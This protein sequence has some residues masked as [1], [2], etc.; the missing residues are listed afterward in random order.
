MNGKCSAKH[1]AGV[2]EIVPAALVVLAACSMPLSASADFSNLNQQLHIQQQKSRFRLMLEQVQESAQRR[3]AVRP[4]PA[5]RADSSKPTG[6]GDWTQ[7]LRLHPVSVTDPVSRATVS[8]STARFR[9]RQAY[10]R[11]Q[12]RIL[13][14]RQQRHALLGARRT[15]APGAA[16][17]YAHKRR[18]LVRYR[19][20]NQKQSLRRKLGR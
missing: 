14:H 16:N 4:A 13:E 8:A 15:G 20:Q 3:G 6:L 18:A 1:R 2:A 12:Q 17:S 10:E 19:R 5:T 9:A 7:S 11:D